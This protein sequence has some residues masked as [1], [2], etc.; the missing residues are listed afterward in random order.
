M[1]LLKR[2]EDFNN[3]MRMFSVGERKTA[4]WAVVTL[5]AGKTTLKIVSE[6]NP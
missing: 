1:F 6:T 2:K 3:G 4:E 5:D